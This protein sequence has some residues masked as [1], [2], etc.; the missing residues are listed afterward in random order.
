MVHHLT[1]L[2][3]DLN[4]VLIGASSQ[5]VLV[6]APYLTFLPYSMAEEMTDPLVLSNS[7]LKW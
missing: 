1:P 2:V 6:Y 3:D 5:I 7:V 4:G